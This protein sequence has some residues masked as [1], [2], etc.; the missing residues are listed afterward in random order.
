MGGLILARTLRR[1]ADGTVDDRKRA[2]DEFVARW[3]VE[4]RPH[5]DDEE[6]LLLPII[7]RS[8]LRERL[9]EEHRALRERAAQCERCASA[10]AQD[11]KAVRRLGVL[12]HDHIRWEE[13]VL[14]EAIQRDHPAE[15]ASIVHEAL[16]IED[17]RPGSR[18][19][20]SLT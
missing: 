18:A 7:D 5:F 3:T 16:A 19:R 15:L 13:R 1:A 11:A 6:R 12:L 8:D 10:V 20:R 4:L 17:R 14:F 2:V 9:V